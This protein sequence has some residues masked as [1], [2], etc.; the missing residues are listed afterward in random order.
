MTYLTKIKARIIEQVDSTTGEIKKTKHFFSPRLLIN[1][2]FNVFPMSHLLHLHIAPEKAAVNPF[3]VVKVLHRISS[4]FILVL[5]HHSSSACFTISGIKSTTSSF[6]ELK[7]TI[8]IK[9]GTP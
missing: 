6:V 8:F 4:V 5:P 2:V 9:A 7:N 1:F 3:V